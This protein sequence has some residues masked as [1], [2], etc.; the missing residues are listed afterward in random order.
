MS[1]PLAKCNLNIDWVLDYL[2]SRL[3]L[4]MPQNA[5]NCSSI[6]ASQ[7]PNC[8]NFENDEENWDEE[9]R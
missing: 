9:E 7:L 3:C 2:L 5:M 4:G 6:N 1:A 8:E